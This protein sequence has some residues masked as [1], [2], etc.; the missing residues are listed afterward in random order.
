MKYLLL[1]CVAIFLI[2]YGIRSMI[3]GFRNEP[4]SYF[5]SIGY[6]GL[7]GVKN[8]EKYQ[9]ILLGFVLLVGGVAIFFLY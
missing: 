2:T 5:M 6:D 7:K 1:Y 3:A 9:N 4:R 8:Y